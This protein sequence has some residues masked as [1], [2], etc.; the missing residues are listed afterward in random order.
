[1]GSPSNGDMYAHFAGQTTFYFW[2]DGRKVRPGP[3]A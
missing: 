2:A 1:M 3:S